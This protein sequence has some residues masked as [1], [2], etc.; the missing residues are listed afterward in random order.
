MTA[1]DRI[2]RTLDRNARAVEMKPA[3]GQGTAVTKI[4]MRD[5]LTAE[6]EEGAWKLTVDVPP[7]M[8][9]DDRGPNPG[10]LGRAA[11]GSCLAL[12]YTMWAA[13]RG[14]PISSLA[15]EV[16]ADYDARGMLCS[17]EIPAGY[18]EVR[19]VVDV[20]SDA[21]ESEV[22]KVLDEA[23]EYSTFLDVYRRPHSVRRIV[24]CRAPRS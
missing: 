12:G 24:R 23:D 8:G 5:G 22:V 19:W 10:L 4:T 17:A 15:V 6:V 21:P 14:V 11:L 3:A 13:R 16:Q 20:E 2:K 1:A 9:G 7:K 18:L